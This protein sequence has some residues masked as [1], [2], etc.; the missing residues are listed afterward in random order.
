GTFELKFVR[1]GKQFIQCAPLYL[2]A[3][4]APAPLSMLIELAAGQVIEDIKLVTG[5]EPQ[6]LQIK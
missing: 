5:G 4:E 2:D 3:R 6:R 1:P